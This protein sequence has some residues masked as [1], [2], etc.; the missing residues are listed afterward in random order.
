MSEE[1]HTPGPWECWPSQQV[2]VR[3][4]RDEQGRRVTH[5][6]A[7]CNSATQD[8]VA[9]ARLMAAAP[10]MAERLERYEEGLKTILAHA[11]SAIECC[12]E[13]GAGYLREVC[14]IVDLLLGEDTSED[15]EK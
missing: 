4:C 7:H 10:E 14:E 5:F 13:P 15:E 11:G 1:K 3:R 6:L 8:N 12:D 9:N 2:V